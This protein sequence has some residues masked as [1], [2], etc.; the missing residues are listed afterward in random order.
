MDD[1][2]RNE[3]KPNLQEMSQFYADAAAGTLPTYSFIEPR[4]AASKNSNATKLPSYGLANHQHPTASVKEGE[5]LMKNMYEALR[6]GPKWNSTLF[7]ITYDEH[8]GFFDHVPPPQTGVPNPDGILSAKGFNYTRLGIRIPTI[9][10]SPWI[11][12]GTLVHEAPDSQ[13]PFPTSQWEL[14][15][16]PA[17]VEKLLDFKGPTLSKRTEWAA[18]F[19]HLLSR[20][21]PRTDC[22]L[23]LPT[24]SP[25]AAGEHARQLG[26]LIDE[27]AQGVVKMLCD[28]NGGV[29]VT[30]GSKAATTSQSRGGE[31]AYSEGGKAFDHCLEL[32]ICVPA[33]GCGGWVRTNEHFSE[34][35]SAMW[36]KWLE[37]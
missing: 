4:I 30:A 25:P 15:S 19:E 37:K 5:R 29:D 26:L 16:I 33:S 34:F 24:V 22:P 8:G 6:K 20:D 31:A 13:K 32:G 28:M 35:R 1:L 14:S 27:H 23:E 2:R 3:S 36:A 17:T 11:E 7:I 18:T 12:K 10:I 9:A 21:T